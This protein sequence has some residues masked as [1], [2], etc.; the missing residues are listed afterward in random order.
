MKQVFFATAHP[1]EDDDGTIYNLSVGY[2]KKIGLAYLITMLP[3]SIGETDEKPLNGGKVIAT[4][5]A[6]SQQT[7]SHSFGMTQKYFIFIQQPLTV[8]LWKLA[9]S[10]FIGWS[11]LETFA[12]NPKKDVNFS[13]IS[14]DTGEIILNIKA[15]PFF[16]FHVVNAYDDDNEIVLDLCC[17]R[18]AQIFHQLYLEEARDIQPEKNAQYFTAQLRRYR[19][20]IVSG[21]TEV[22]KLEKEASGQD[23][24]ILSDVCFDLPRINDKYNR[25]RHRYVYGACSRDNNIDGLLLS[26]LV[27]VDVETKESLIWAE[28]DN[29]VSEPVFVAAPDGQQEDDGVVL[30]S[31]YD[32]MKDNSFLLVLD[33]RTFTEVAR[34]EV[35]LRF[36]PSFHGR[37]FAPTA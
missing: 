16:F 2:D 5:R 9:A 35:P 8:N 17:Y 33:A 30:S 23:Y 15:D 27:K 28:E 10:R 25:L 14:R 19:L 20:P 18:D 26:K 29:I 32:S 3:P 11:I 1:H 4:I 34:A 21:Q 13:V 6:S 31:V 36:A 37:F 12:W 7:Y 22:S 24:E